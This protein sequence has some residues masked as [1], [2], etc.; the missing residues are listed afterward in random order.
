MLYA[1]DSIYVWKTSQTYIPMWD[2]QFAC[3]GLLPAGNNVYL[4][5]HDPNFASGNSFL[6]A[7]DAQTG[8]EVWPNRFV[9]PNS[10]GFVFSGLVYDCNV[11]LHLLC[12]RQCHLC[13]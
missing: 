2:N 1:Y 5:A 8:L 4:V 11:Q 13:R 7:L 3:Y 12:V 10:M 9:I 6:V